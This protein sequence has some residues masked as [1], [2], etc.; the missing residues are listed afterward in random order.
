MKL[1]TDY[2]Y[3]ELGSTFWNQAGCTVLETSGYY[4]V[5]VLNVD[6]DG[7]VYCDNAA[8]CRAAG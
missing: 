8:G 4:M 6:T 5:V 7:D 1:D 2:P 3:L